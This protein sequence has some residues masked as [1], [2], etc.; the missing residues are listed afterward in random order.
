MKIYM[1]SLLFLGL[2][3]CFCFQVCCQEDSPT[4]LELDRVYELSLKEGTHYNSSITVPEDIAEGENLY[5]SAY[6]VI[7]DPF[8]EPLLRIFSSAGIELKFC[9]ADLSNLNDVCF[10]PAEKLKKGDKLTI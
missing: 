8:E 3:L 4:N 10:I 7:N 9:Q 5:I 6:S 1:R 2:M